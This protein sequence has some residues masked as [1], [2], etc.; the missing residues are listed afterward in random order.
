MKA[1]NF[2]PYSSSAIQTGGLRAVKCT[3]HIS[4]DETDKTFRLYAGNSIYA[5]C[6]SP[7]LTLEHLHWG[8]SLPA[9]YDLRF[10]S[11][12]SRLTHFS[13]VEAAPDRSSTTVGGMFGGKIIL[14]AETLEEVQKTWRENKVWVVPKEM[15]EQERFQRRRLENFSWRIMSKV[16]QDSHQQKEKEN[17]RD[18]A[19]IE[20]DGKEVTIKNK[21]DANRT[22]F[23]S[24]ADNSRRKL[25]KLKNA[26]CAMN[27]FGGRGE[28]GDTGGGG[29]SSGVATKKSLSAAAN[30]D[31]EG[32]VPFPNSPSKIDLVS[33]LQAQTSPSVPS[34]PNIS[35]SSATTT[36]T[37]GGIETSGILGT[38]PKNDLAG[39]D[40]MGQALNTTGLQSTPASTVGMP[41]TGPATTGGVC[42]ASSTPSQPLSSRQ[43]EIQALLQ[44]QKAGGRG[45]LSRRASVDSS[46]MSDLLKEFQEQQREREREKEKERQRVL[47]KAKQG[48]GEGKDEEDEDDD[49]NMKDLED[50]ALGRFGSIG[51]TVGACGAGGGLGKGGGLGGSKYSRGSVDF[52]SLAEENHEIAE[53]IANV[54][55]D[56]TFRE[57]EQVEKEREK[58]DGSTSSSGTSVSSRGGADMIQSVGNRKRTS[59]SMERR[60]QEVARLEGEGYGLSPLALP[61]EDQWFDF[62]DD[63]EEEDGFNEE[64]SGRERFRDHI[65]K[66]KSNSPFSASTNTLSTLLPESTASPVPSPQSVHVGTPGTGVSRGIG[67]KVMGM[68]K[69]SRDRGKTLKA[70]RYVPSESD[71]DVLREVGT[72][73]QTGTAGVLP[74]PKHRIL[75]T[76]DDL[77]S[78]MGTS[79]FGIG[80]GGGSG[81]S[82]VSAGS[83]TGAT[84]LPRRTSTSTFDR[85][86]GKLGKG[87]LCVE[88]SD[89]GTGDFRSP[90]FQI[91]D[92]FNGSSIS[93]LRYR[94]HRIY[95]GKLPIP[96]HMP[97]IRT[98]TYD[99][100]STLVVTMA[101][102]VT[103]LEVDLIYG[104]YFDV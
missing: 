99:E 23:H 7:E 83:N 38:I 19:A 22:T 71:I 60:R 26:L 47:R 61:E 63:Q 72:S 95:R 35:V 77:A 43:K 37:D 94:K 88:Y 93:P 103:G 2:P 96:D 82:G 46:G 39:I 8:P 51:S 53:A 74:T 79:A 98:E 91:V 21:T 58:D 65:G 30:R 97:S 10:L 45:G 15:S 62:D 84:T 40:T 11:Q 9:G 85:A 50:I 78:H 81:I 29:A 102:V 12:S 100:A 5:F 54:R 28:A 33:M 64:M 86:M 87:S 34:R 55:Y 52:S 36:T 24:A 56:D 20:K 59:S 42:D 66:T 27:K 4:F 1:A 44:L 31:R 3:S 17:N 89:H 41:I 6:I 49:F 69:Q 90:S 80:N 67:K 16:M 70:M 104:K 73:S 14:A 76:I 101:D 75:Q 92:N 18:V 48:D 32:N 57:K 68:G 25:C 13:T